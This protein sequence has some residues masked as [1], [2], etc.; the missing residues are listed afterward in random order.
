[1]NNI[2]LSRLRRTMVVAESE[3]EPAKLRVL[4]DEKSYRLAQK[5]FKD[6]CGQEADFSQFHNFIQ[7]FD[8]LLARFGGQ[9]P[10][11]RQR[12]N[13]QARQA[14]GQKPLSERKKGKE[15]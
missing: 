9:S 15:E 8:R 14:G 2:N 7:D 5:I 4:T 13:N 3:G 6:Y 12:P 11:G 1:M 10:N